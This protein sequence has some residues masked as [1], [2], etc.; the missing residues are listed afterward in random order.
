MFMCVSV[1]VAT[2]GVGGGEP[3]LV[4]PTVVKRALT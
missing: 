1:C 2:V 3:S 4:A